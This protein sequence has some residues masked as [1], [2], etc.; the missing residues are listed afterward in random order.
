MLTPK[1]NFLTMLRGEIP[2]YMPSYF[3]M[4]AAGIIEELLT[5]N[6]AP[7]GPIVTALGVTYVGSP[8]NNY[9][10][11]P[12]PGM[13]ILDDITKWRDVVKTPDLSGRDWEGIYKKQVDKIDRV[14]KA[15]MVDGGDYFLTLVALM[16]FENTLMALYEE[17][18][19]VKELLEYISAF[20][21]QVL[22]A[23]IQ[24]VKPDIYI[25]MDDDA[26]Y[27]AP[28]FSVEMYREFFKPFH[29]RHCDLVKDAGILIE[30]HDCGKSEE[31]IDDWLELGIDGWNPCQITNDLVGIKK[32]YGDR[33]ALDGCWDSQG[34]LGSSA[35][36]DE[37]LLQALYE[38]VDTFAPGGRFAFSAGVDFGRTSPEAE[39]KRAV[40]KK[41][42]DEY[43]RDWY[44]THGYC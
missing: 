8:D 44:K 10:A 25:L 34:I 15:I 29:K 16:G 19:E 6:R 5:P 12:A 36:D 20:Y 38:Y 18:D 42:F 23:Q 11:M 9:G 31:F 37:T 30:R 33:L 4:H 41:F 28:F 3:D 22:K 14:N 7:D 39:A 32:K 21:I 17:P 13:N 1:E 40:I 26:A 35:V 24:Y 2:E 43:A 27:R